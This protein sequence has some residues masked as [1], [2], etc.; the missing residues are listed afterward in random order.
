MTNILRVICVENGG[1]YYY[2]D[3]LTIGKTYDVIEFSSYYEVINDNGEK[4]IFNKIRFKLLSEVRE[5]LINHILKDSGVQKKL[6]S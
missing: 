4:E 1:V 6:I 3:N 2:S 5:E